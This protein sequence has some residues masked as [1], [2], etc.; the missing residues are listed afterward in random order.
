MLRADVDAVRTWFALAEIE[1]RFVGSEMVSDFKR[2]FMRGLG[3][4]APTLVT[5]ALVV[6]AYRFIDQ[7]IGQYIT[8]GV[9]GLYSWV[10]ESEPHGALGIDQ[11]VALDLGDPID[12]WNA[13]TGQRLTSHYKVLTSRGLASTDEETRLRAESL[14][15]EALWDLA[16]RKWKVFNLT[17]FAIAILLIYFMGYFLASFIGRTTWKIVENLVERIP[18]VGGIYPSIKQVTDLF[19]DDKKL[20][21]S[22]VVAVQYPRKGLWSVGLVTGRPM[23]AIKSEDSRDLTTVFIPSSPTPFTG[24]TITVA[25]EDLLELPISI[26]EAFRYTI[27]GGIVKP[28]DVAKPAESSTAGD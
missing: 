27:S 3:A 20:E 18:L 16:T 26:D 6:W 11:Q 24:Y 22:A 10:L 12:E 13:V 21:F 7:N 1:R 5:I 23:G 8:R 15:R 14:R 19:I 25:R 28:G 17:G 4:V 9:I 2:F